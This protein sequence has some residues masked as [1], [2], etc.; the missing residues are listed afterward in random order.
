MTD[1]RQ[2][3]NYIGSKTKLTVSYS[4]IG[5]PPHA[6]LVVIRLLALGLALVESHF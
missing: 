6:H 5:T 2:E 4:A 3:G 1:Q